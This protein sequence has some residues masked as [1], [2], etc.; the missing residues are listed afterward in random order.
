MEGG[1][2]FFRLSHKEK[3]TY[4]IAIDLSTK[5]Y[6]TQFAIEEEI[7]LQGQIVPYLPKVND[8]LGSLVVK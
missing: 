2:E 7:T 4:P 6:A 1:C 3:E 8:T 5:C